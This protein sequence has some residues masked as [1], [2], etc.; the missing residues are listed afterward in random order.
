[1]N[2]LLVFTATVLAG[3]WA[4]AGPLLAHPRATRGRRAA[5]VALLLPTIAA[6]GAG[7]GYTGGTFVSIGLFGFDLD[8]RAPWWD[9]HLPTA[10]AVWGALAGAVAV[11]L[12]LRRWQRPSVQAPRNEAAVYTDDGFQ[13]AGRSRPAPQRLRPTDVS[14]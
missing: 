5:A 2:D 6:A 3:A 12:C 10:G 14:R 9:R 8:G 4:L 13:P 1:M 7:A 11:I